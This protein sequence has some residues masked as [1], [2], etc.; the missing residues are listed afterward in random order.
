MVIENLITSP[1][2][3][4]TFELVQPL[5][6]VVQPFFYKLSLLV[7]GLLGIYFLMLLAR[8]YY[9]RKKVK[10]LED[11][12]YDL[13]QLNRHHQLK[14]SNYNKKIIA[15]CWERIISSVRRH[16][17]LNSAREKK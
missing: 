5:I 1:A 10:I 6:N 17:F 16:H 15:R 12:R 7:G 4:Q 2:N 11:I 14:S 3:N 8:I 13:D 9:D